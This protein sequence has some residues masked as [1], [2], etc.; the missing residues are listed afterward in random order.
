MCNKCNP[1]STWCLHSKPWVGYR[2]PITSVSSYGLDRFRVGLVFRFSG[3]LIQDKSDLKQPTKKNQNKSSASKADLIKTW[4]KI[5]DDD[6]EDGGERVI[7]I[8]VRSVMVWSGCS[9]IPATAR[10]ESKRY[11][12]TRERERHRS[13]AAL[14]HGEGKIV[15]KVVWLARF[16]EKRFKG[17]KCNTAVNHFIFLL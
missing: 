1:L 6:I 14:W 15:C 4:T 9:L 17:T 8:F 11:H 12:E 5:E 13:T 2:G 3:G 7:I 16:K 10:L